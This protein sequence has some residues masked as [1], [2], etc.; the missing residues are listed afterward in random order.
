M[1][2]DASWPIIVRHG[3]LS[4]TALLD[5]FEVSDGDRAAIESERRPHCVEL[6]HPAHG[7]AVIRDNKPLLET[8]L[9]RCLEDGLTPADWYRTLN[10]RVFFWPTKNRLETLMSAEA[11]RATPKLVITVDTAA[12]VG[13][14]GHKVTLSPINSGATR[15]YAVARGAST[16]RSLADFDWEARRRYGKNAV[17]EVAVD[18]GVSDITEVAESAVRHLPDGGTELLWHRDG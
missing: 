11:Y 9:A 15:P 7:R 6:E 2:V 10:S 8:R 17:A 4:T 13:R 16:F 1:A 14:D 5:L 3:L 18:Y 12:L